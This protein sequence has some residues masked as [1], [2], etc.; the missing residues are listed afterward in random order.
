M[1]WTINED[2]FNTKEDAYKEYGKNGFNLVIERVFPNISDARTIARENRGHCWLC[3]IDQRES[4]DNGGGA[5]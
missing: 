1:S 3:K 5:D 4:V 2:T